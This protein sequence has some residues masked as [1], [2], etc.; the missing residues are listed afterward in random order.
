MK[1]TNHKPATPLPFSVTDDGTFLTI[2]NGNGLNTTP[3]LRI[4]EYG[5]DE[6]KE[7]RTD[8]AYLVHAGN[9]Y[10][11]LIETLQADIAEHLKHEVADG[12]HGPAHKAINLLHQLGEAS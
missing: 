6:V 4:S 1:S 10:Q 12:G 3:D 11:K 7:L 9:A 2:V 5:A 8:Y